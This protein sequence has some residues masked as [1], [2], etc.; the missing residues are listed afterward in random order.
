MADI[1]KLVPHT[2]RRR[3]ERKAQLRFVTV[4][5]SVAV[6]YK[7]GRLEAEA[8]VNLLETWCLLLEI[9]SGSLELPQML[10][11]RH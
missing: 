4:R 2:S 6:S 8:A 5:G 10:P 7:T 11:M 1:R 9:I 3:A